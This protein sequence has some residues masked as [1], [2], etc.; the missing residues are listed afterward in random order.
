MNKLYRISIAFGATPLVIGVSIFILWYFT[1]ADFLTTAGLFTILGGLFFVLIG[2][3]CLIIYLWCEARRKTSS[4]R[5]FKRGLFA[6]GIIISNFPAAFV[7]VLLVTCVPL[8]SRVIGI[9]DVTQK[10]TVLLSSEKYQSSV[11]SIDI[12]IA[13]HIDGSAIIYQSYEGGERYRTYNIEK[14]EV[15]LKI[16]GDWYD[17]KCLI[18][19]EP[20]DVG[21][22][23]LKI[24]YRLNS[25]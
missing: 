20:H 23:N 22:G 15:G 5:L 21:S 18:E 12:L 9:D 11:H 24:K 3:V 4:K 1:R 14:G 2:V 7:I 17:E 13:G 19:Y 16:G 8:W 25:I 10:T 6:I